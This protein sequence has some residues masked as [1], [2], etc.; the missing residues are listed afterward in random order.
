MCYVVQH[1]V[2]GNGW[3]RVYQVTKN[4][5][6]SLIFYSIGGCGDPSGWPGSGRGTADREEQGT[7]GMDTGRCLSRGH[8]SC[9]RPNSITEIGFVNTKIRIR[10]RLQAAF[11]SVAF[12]R[13][14][15]QGR[16]QDPAGKGRVPQHSH[17]P[18]PT[19]WRPIAGL[20]CSGWWLPSAAIGR[21]GQLGIGSA[22]PPHAGTC[23]GDTRAAPSGWAWR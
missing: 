7:A 8:T 23:T 13:D 5:V 15:I 10:A 21:A 6:R 16:G 19:A 1:A 14:R 12:A 20:P 2:E 3:L 11:G 9:V 17:R 22:L 4:W 18:T